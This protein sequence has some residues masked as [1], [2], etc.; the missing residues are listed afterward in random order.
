MMVPKEQVAYH[1]LNFVHFSIVP[2]NNYKFIDGLPG[3]DG[4]VGEK[5]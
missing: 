4:E 1:T 2:L 3:A 5:G